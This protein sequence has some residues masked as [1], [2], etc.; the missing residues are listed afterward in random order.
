MSEKEAWKMLQEASDDLDVDDFKD[1][2]KILSKANPAV[3]YA[4]LERELRKRCS[5][6]YLIGLKKEVSPAYT[7]VNLQ[8]ETGKTHTLGVFA[9]SAACPRPILMDAWPKDTTENLER[10]GDSGVPMERG[11]PVRYLPTY[12]ARF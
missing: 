1:A 10:L 7:N 3:T 6:M 8:G 4:Q 12:A 9:R 2:I 11:V 5:N